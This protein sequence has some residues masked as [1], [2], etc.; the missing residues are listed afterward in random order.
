M[1]YIKPFI[2]RIGEEFIKPQNKNTNQPIKYS[3]NYDTSQQ[4]ISNNKD[5][6]ITQ[7]ASTCS[8][9]PNLNQDKYNNNKSS[10]L[11][12]SDSPGSTSILGITD[13]INNIE[14]TSNRNLSR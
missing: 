5:T 3:S 2:K 1:T 13:S 8:K 11:S 4:A 9:H 10:F 12:T 7:N 6:A 14:K